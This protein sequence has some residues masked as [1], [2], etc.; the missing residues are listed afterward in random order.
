M[1]EIV[2]TEVASTAVYQNV[3]LE[4]THSGPLGESLGSRHRM[5]ASW[6]THFPPVLPEIIIV[7]ADNQPPPVSCKFDG[8]GAHFDEIPDT[9]YIIP[10]KNALAQLLSVKA[11]SDAVQS[12][13]IS[14]EA[15][16]LP[17]SKPLVYSDVW[18]GSVLR[19]NP[20]FIRQK[21]KILAIQLYFDEVETA[22]PLGSNKGVY[23]MSVFYWSWLNLP[24]AYRSNL[25]SI[26]LLG[27]IQSDLLKLHGPSKFL[28]PFIDD[29]LHFQNGVELNVRG[30]NDVWHAVLL[31]F[32]GDMPASNFIG[33]FKETG[34]AYRPCRLCHIK[35]KDLDSVHHQRDS[36]L[37]DNI[38]HGEN[39][40]ALED[41]L[42][43]KQARKA[44]SR[45]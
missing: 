3:F 41:P 16:F 28:K 18:D 33:G 12:S 14:N 40:V 32:A 30:T 20:I 21:G 42:L 7:N 17:T 44:L 1:A 24:P 37:R 23:K 45:E 27:L 6:A 9:G 38:S 5:E 34:S 36:L 43:S 29:L 13:F 19:N 2:P 15:S 26:Q 10:F 31:N 35:R 8:D 4:S 11:V 22:N 39:I 25:R